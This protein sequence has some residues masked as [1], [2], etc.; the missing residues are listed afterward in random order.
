MV[1]DGTWYRVQVDLNPL[2]RAFWG[3]VRVS[4]AYGPLPDARSEMTA[5]PATADFMLEC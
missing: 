2:V 5:A 4:R 3:R 1:V